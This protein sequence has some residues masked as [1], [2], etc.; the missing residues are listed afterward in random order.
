MIS[1][2]VYILATEVAFLQPLVASLWHFVL[3]IVLHSEVMGS[4]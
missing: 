1:R 4:Y 3:R 2:M